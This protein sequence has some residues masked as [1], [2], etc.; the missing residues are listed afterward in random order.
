[1]PHIIDRRMLICY[2]KLMSCGEKLSATPTRLKDMFAFIAS[3]RP[4]ASWWGVAWLPAHGK[5]RKRR[6]A[7][8][9]FEKITAW[10]AGLVG[11]R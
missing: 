9:S 3:A 10:R 1:M 8:V 5:Q 4:Q 6:G 2:H 11:G 7:D